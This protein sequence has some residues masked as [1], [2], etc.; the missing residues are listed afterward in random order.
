[1]F[2][3]FDMA[4]MH[5]INHIFYLLQIMVTFM[6]IISPIKI[7]HLTDKQKVNLICNSTYYSTFIDDANSPFGFIIGKKF[8][9][10]VSRNKYE[11]GYTR[12][13]TLLIHKCYVNDFLN[14][15]NYV[16]IEPNDVN[17]M[18]IWMRKGNYFYISWEKRKLQFQKKISSPQQNDIIASIRQFYTANQQG[19]FF[20]GG[21]PGTG[22]STLLY[23]MGNEY[24]GSQICK[25][26]KP[27]DPGDH[28]ETLYTAVSP[29]KE[30]P[31]IVLLDEIDILLNDICSK[32]DKGG[33][34]E[35]HRYIPIE[36]FNKPTYNSFF[37]DINNHIY[38]N[39][40]FLLTS[41]YTKEELDEKYSPC[42]LRKGR[43]DECFVI[44]N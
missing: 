17:S 12:E 28:F 41:N 2:S 7:I 21:P 36:I 10:H 11:Y 22:K 8:I 40:I 39:V 15:P 14:Q 29:T 34:I 3:L 31:L 25:Q 5:V 19:V 20:I 9:G 27:S 32:E 26:Y 1:M 6:N 18:D 38:P 13:I 30:S 37:D 33:G 43:I 44:K 24:I 16:N 42:F 23:L 4:I 35:R